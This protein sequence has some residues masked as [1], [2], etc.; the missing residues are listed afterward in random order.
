[1]KYDNKAEV[2]LFFFIYQ[3]HFYLIMSNCE[4]FSSSFSCLKTLGC[5]FGLR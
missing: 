4:A 2:L 1:M 5:S 3:N